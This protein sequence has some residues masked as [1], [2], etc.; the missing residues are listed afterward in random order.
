MKKKII[1]LLLAVM[2]LCGCGMDT[3]DPEETVSFFYPRADILYGAQDGVIAAE[4]REASIS[5]N[6]LEQQL[7]IYLSGPKTE[8]FVSP[9]PAGTALLGIKQDQSRLTLTLSEEFFSLEGVDLTLACAS[10]AQTC[11]GIT[12]TVELTLRSGNGEQR[13]T[14]DRNSFVFFDDAD[15]IDMTIGTEPA[16]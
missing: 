9:F 14:I 13:I 2:L 10:L 3:A 1:L 4:L 15:A 16:A 6:S 12:D 8:G 5:G 11:F 7:Y